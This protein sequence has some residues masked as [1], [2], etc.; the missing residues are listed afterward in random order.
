[1]QS[2]AQQGPW[3]EVYR[4]SATLYYTITD[5]S[6]PNAVDRLLEDVSV[7]SSSSHVS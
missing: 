5:S 2:I 3:T 6:P 7:P 4:L 1:V